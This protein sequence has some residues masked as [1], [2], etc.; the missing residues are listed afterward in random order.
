MSFSPPVDHDR[1][2]VLYS[3]ESIRPRIEGCFTM[4]DVHVS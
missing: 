1:M 3:E 2:L 4:L